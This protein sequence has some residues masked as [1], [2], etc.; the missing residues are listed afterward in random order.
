MIEVTNMGAYVS[1]KVV[2]LDKAKLIVEQ[3]KEVGQSV[4]LCHG[5]FDL[6][7]PGHIRHFES[8]KRLCDVLIVSITSDKFVGER[9]GKGRPVYDERLRAYSVA[10]LS[11]VDFVVVSHYNLGVDV[12]KEMKPNYYIKG[13][14]FVDKQTPG[15]IKERETISEVGGEIK[16]TIEQPL[17]TTNI[18]KYIQ[19]EVKRKDLLVCVDR[20][21]TLI[22]DEGFLGKERNW[23]ENVVFKDDV[24][25]FLQYLQSVYNT[26]ICVISNQ[27]GVARGFFGTETVDEINDFI[28]NELKKRSVH[29][30]KWKYCPY[31]DEY[32]AKINPDLYFDPK[33]VQAKTERKPSDLMVVECLTDIKKDKRD[34][35]KVLVLGDNKDDEGLAK[36]MDSL[37]INVNGKSFFDI[38][39]EWDTI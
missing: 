6:L 7:H 26:T 33:Y 22:E 38:K 31:A 27:A 1:E 16:Y 25:S 3:S 18:I 28:D 35:F 32:Y 30:H 19:S 17:S 23:K 39:K 20:D 11:F 37:F 8:A 36:S 24:I 12:I 29:I 15:I 2:S 13:P 4:G 10:S 9:K 34:F 5:G 21:G 14:D